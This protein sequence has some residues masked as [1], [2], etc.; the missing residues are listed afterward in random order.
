MLKKMEENPVSYTMMYGNEDVRAPFFHQC[1]F[2]LS[3]RKIA[4][5]LPI[6]HLEVYVFCTL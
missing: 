5:P 3:F 1:D 2:F 4:P 6:P